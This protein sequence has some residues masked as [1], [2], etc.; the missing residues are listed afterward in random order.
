[1][2]TWNIILQFISIGLLIIAI[3]FRKKPWGQKLLY[4]SL[5]MLAVYIL[6]DFPQEFMEGYR[7]GASR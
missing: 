2:E 7:A 3:I 5:G 4:F 1:M 6:T